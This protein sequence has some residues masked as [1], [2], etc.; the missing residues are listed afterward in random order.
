[1]QKALN[2]IFLPSFGG[3]KR[4]WLK[5]D[6]VAAIVVTAIA[7][8]ESLGFAAIVGLPI[9]TGLYCA[10]L[11]PIVFAL[12]TSS[13][14]LVVGADS[15][16]AALVASG[17]ATVAAASSPEFAGAVALL[18]LLTGLILLAMS[19]LRM[20]F[21]ADLISR[22]VLVGFLAGVGIQLI[23]GRL[24]E[25]LGIEAHGGLL[26]KL[27]ILATHTN[28][29]HLVTFALSL[30]TFAVII[31]AGRFRL[32]GALIGLIVA[33][34][35][36]KLFDLPRYGVEVIGDIPS[37]LPHLVIP[38]LSI[39]DMVVLFS[40]ALAIAIVILAQS[41]A[42]IR[43]FA[44]KY[45]EPVDDNKDLMALGFANIASAITQGF[46]INGS[47]PRSTAGEV[48]GGHS[49]LVNIFMAL[50]IGV[51][52]LFASDVLGMVP[53]A[54]L[55][56]VVCSIGLHLIKPGQ[57]RD[58][59][60][61]HKAEFGI[62]MLAL[63]AV[64]VLGVQQGVMLAVLGS[65]V[66]RLWREYRPPDDVLLR[67]GK[68]NE[69]AATRIEGSHKHTSRPA[70]V[71]IYHFESD[72]FF[73]NATYFSRRIKQAVADAKYPV[74]S[75]ILDAGT[76]S[77]IDYT[78]AMALRRAAEQFMADEIRF[79]IAHVSPAF[80]K[81][82]RQYNV[83]QLIGRDNIY[84]SLRSAVWAQSGTKRTIVEMVQ[85]LNLSPRS[86]VVIGGGVLE[87]LGLRE[88]IEADLVVSQRVYR[89]L[90]DRGWSEE[91]HDDGKRVLSHR[92]YKVMTT[93]MGM[94]LK[95][96]A[97]GAFMMSGVRFMG[98]DDLVH[99]KEKLGRS[100]DLSDVKL[101]RAYQ[102]RVKTGKRLGKQAIT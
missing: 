33:I 72:L 58:I 41:S 83:T 80:A 86:Y 25:M 94:S 19:V 30:G 21:L 1:M 85:R 55:G 28:Q 37:G 26:G 44:A 23:V 47:P 16:T 38:Q 48:A 3:Y 62:T 49:Q 9:Q 90:R 69:W 14:H 102:K 73:E 75:V 39:P 59:W 29:I 36:T 89:E 63:G 71:V 66:E 93:F 45:D 42:V 10:L 92:G 100:K 76:M 32:P 87:V 96:L 82:L 18:G 101:I 54:A 46:A 12:L 43:S 64:A 24:P 98:L 77:D 27:V 68:I 40:S 79:S 20:G 95:R 6:F 67:D 91:V 5:N 97:R 35:A 57:L 56:A 52:L 99:S 70:G 61:A 7:I 13:K 53:M 65:L 84:D 31:L 17:A 74:T 50:L 22:P 2:Q 8:P 88:S 11:A 15:A 78:G 51:V 34:G 81:M 4:R 60:Q